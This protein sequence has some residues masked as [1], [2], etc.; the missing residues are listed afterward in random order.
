MVPSN[1]D[2]KVILENLILN[3]FDRVSVKSKFALK[4]QAQISEL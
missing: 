1:S 3:I 4:L 2:I